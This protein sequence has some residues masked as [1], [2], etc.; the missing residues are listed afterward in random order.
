MTCDEPCP[1]AG[2]DGLPD[3]EDCYT[4]PLDRRE[5]DAMPAHE[6]ISVLEGRVERLTLCLQEIHAAL[7]RFLG[8]AP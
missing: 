4:G 7:A 6:P 8:E 5:A 2:K 1:K 3:N